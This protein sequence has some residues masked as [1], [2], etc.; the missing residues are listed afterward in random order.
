MGPE[1]TGSSDGWQH[2]RGRRGGYSRLMRQD[3]A[4][5]LH[6]LTSHRQIMDRLIAEHGGR[7]AN[8]AG[9]SVLAEFPSAV[10]AVQCAVKVQEAVS[11]AKR[12]YA[13]RAP[14]PVWDRGSCRGCDGPRQGDLFG[15]GVRI[16]APLESLAEPGRYA[17]P[18]TTHAHVPGP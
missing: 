18:Q 9:D 14:P 13:S 11:Q 15:D 7:I 1:D 4:G 2:L 10:D 12:R 3:E 8:T 16:A 5:T 6:T 17:S